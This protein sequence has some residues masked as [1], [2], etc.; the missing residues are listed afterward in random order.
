MK[1]RRVL[2]KCCQA[3]P[4]SVNST[5]SW[6]DVGATRA[7]GS[8]RPPKSWRLA[9]ALGGTPTL[10]LILNGSSSWLI[11]PRRE[12]LYC[13]NFRVVSG[14]SLGHAFF[15]FTPC[16]SRRKAGSMEPSNPQVPKFSNLNIQ[17]V[18]NP[19]LQFASIPQKLMSWKCWTQTPWP[20]GKIT[21]G[22]R[23]NMIRGFS[24]L[25]SSGASFQ[26][27]APLLVDQAPGWQVQNMGGPG[28]RNPEAPTRRLS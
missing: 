22:L 5:R 21:K 15:T 24:R 17:P 14:S 10:L 28:A 20:Q 9:R 23:S 4:V 26:N 25:S 16:A 11:K 6:A 12:Q 27:A 7:V 2:G 13:R 3:R 1:N 18:F 8:S 19:Y